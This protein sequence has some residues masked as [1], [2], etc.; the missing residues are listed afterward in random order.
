[1]KTN[2]EGYNEKIDPALKF[3]NNTHSTRPLHYKQLLIE[4]KTGALDDD[5]EKLD[6]I[7]PHAY[8]T[9]GERGHDKRLWQSQQR[10][11]MTAIIAN[12]REARLI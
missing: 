6:S 11:I 3:N 9:G 7:H 2:N 5:N 12:M 1:M 8:N 10:T 4:R